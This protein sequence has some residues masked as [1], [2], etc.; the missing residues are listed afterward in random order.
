[1]STSAGAAVPAAAACT[2]AASASAS[3]AASSAASCCRRSCLSSAWHASLLLQVGL[4][5]PSPRQPT[6]RPD[7]PIHDD[8][9]R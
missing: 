8:C 2:A 5:L 4:S 1:M 7:H 9:S 6:I 3:A